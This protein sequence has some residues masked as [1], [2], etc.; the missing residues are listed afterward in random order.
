MTVTQQPISNPEN[1]SDQTLQPQ[2]QDTVEARSQSQRPR[3][4]WS[5]K[6]IARS[7]TNFWVKVNNDWVFNMAAMLA[8]NLLMS[9]FPLLA[10]LLAI[11]GLVLGGLGKAVQD[12]FISG[13]TNGIPGGGGELM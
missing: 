9:I 10:L 13:L 2:P 11:L 6:A 3:N 8:Y 1:R 5:A 7:F 12:Q 4:R